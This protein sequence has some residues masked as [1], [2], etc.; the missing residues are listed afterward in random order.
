[1]TAV[2]RSGHGLSE[3][4]GALGRLGVRAAIMIPLGAL[5][6]W[7][8]VGAGFLNYDTAYSL[9]WG[10]DV[11]HLR[12][13][14]FSVPVAP[15]PHPLSTALGVLL[16]PFGDFGQT[17]WVVIAFLSLGALAWVTYELGAHWF[18]PAAGAVA[19]IVILTRIP[20]LSFGV[21][22]YVDIPYVVL[23]LGAVLAEA[24]GKGPRTVLVLLGLAGLL[25]PEAWLFSFAYAAYKRD[26]R[27]LPWAAAA[28]VIW[29]FHDLVLAGDPLHSLLG[30]RDNAEVL[31]RKTGLAAVPGTVPRRLGE[32]LREPGLLGATAGGILVLAL[33]RR[34]AALPIAAGF[35]SIAAF[36]VLAAAGLPILGRYLLLPAALLAVFC[37]AGMFGWLQL[38]RDDRGEPRGWRSAASSC[39][40][41]SS[42][43]PARSSGST[44][45]G[46][47]WARSRRSSPTCTRSS[48]DLPC[49]PVAV[50]NHRPV[51][52]LALWTDIAPEDI[53]SAQLEVPK[54]GVYIDP[55]SERVRRNFTLD[56]HDPKTLTARV[57][58]GFERAAANRSWILYANC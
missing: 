43:P 31:Q 19:G 16:T 21:R 13:P 27:L 18:G 56:P 30:T 58:P 1:M 35:V 41:S 50:P 4:S 8:L 46:P 15:T 40:R 2:Q 20:V 26:L 17:L 7:A 36:C 22:A 51:P 29:M 47:R 25:R 12:R 33:M 23:A 48:G 49:R 14:D 32:I 45:C 10:G 52:H 5:V 6:A 28:P 53:I 11:A 37:G 42:S 24:R 9:L 39:S 54:S 34:R 38:E 57:P 55:A 44:T 3:S